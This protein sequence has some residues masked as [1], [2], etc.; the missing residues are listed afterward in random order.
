MDR[1][2]INLSVTSVEPIPDSREQSFGKVK[3]NP[4]QGYYDL[5]SV[6]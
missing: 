5:T 3:Y 2:N 1:K 6:N 4:I